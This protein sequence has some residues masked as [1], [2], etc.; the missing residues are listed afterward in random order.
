TPSPDP[1]SACFAPPVC[2]PA[3]SN[4][5]RPVAPFAD[6]RPVSSRPHESC[7][8]HAHVPSRSLRIA[9]PC[10]SCPSPSPSASQTGEGD[11]LV[12]GGANVM[13]KM[14]AVQKS[15]KK[16]PPTV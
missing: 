13:I 1:A 12:R 4:S 9:P 2:A 8:L 5:P 3:E 10:V 14:G 16:P 6:A 7:P 11:L 15:E